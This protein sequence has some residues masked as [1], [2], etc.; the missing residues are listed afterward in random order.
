ML[1]EINV[2]LFIYLFKIYII[3]VASI[4]VY[5][6]KK[7]AKLSL[8]LYIYDASVK[9]WLITRFISTIPNSDS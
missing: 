3:D 5:K 1:S 2:F 7:Y 4:T 6:I 9:Y 8:I